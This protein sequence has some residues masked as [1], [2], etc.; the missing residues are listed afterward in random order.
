MFP[1]N[2]TF[3][4]SAALPVHGE[5]S[6]YA[7][8]AVACGDGDDNTNLT[9]AEFSEHVAHLEKLSPSVG[10]LWSALRMNC[11]GWT[12]RP[13]HRYAGPWT[14]N[15]S[16]PIL[17]IGNT[18][19]PVTPLGSAK[20]MSQGYDRSVVLTVDGP[21]HCSVAAISLQAIQYIK[22]YLHVGIMP[23]VGAVC[24][25]DV[26]PFGEKDGEFGALSLQDRA[27]LVAQAKIGESLIRVH[28]R[29]SLGMLLD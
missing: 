10:A 2:I 22:D 8:M 15:T 27:A 29:D 4:P 5:N 6:A 18:A 17:F 25:P 23:P 12:I 1:T 3:S 11:A 14:G 13:N 9:K 24:Q 26:V 19:D 7:N 21:G 16:H 20:K 28:S